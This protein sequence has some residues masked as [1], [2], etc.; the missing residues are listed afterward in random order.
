MGNYQHTSFGRMIGWISAESGNTDRRKLVRDANRVRRWVYSQ[1]D[2]IKLAV[3][4]EECVTASTFCLDCNCENSYVGISLPPEYIN[5]ASMWVNNSSIQMNSR[6][7]EYQDGMMRTCGTKLESNY[8]GVPAPTERD[9][10]PCG[11]C[12]FLGFQASDIADN[13]KLVY[14]Q[15]YDANGQEHT[16]SIKLKSGEYVQ[17][18]CEVKAIRQPS[19]ITLPDDLVGGVL[20]AQLDTF[21]ILSEYKP[22]EHKPA[23]RRMTLPVCDGQQVLVRGTR[24]HHDLYW[25][26]ETAETDNELAVIAVYRY[27][28]HSASQ[29]PT[30]GQQQLADY[31][32]QQAIKYLTGDQK[33]ETGASTVARF[34]H[35]HGIRRHNTLKTMG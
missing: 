5:A 6:W 30:D 23:Y 14:I 33:R 8:V 29:S 21:R 16:D 17:T 10:Y 19:G 4:V 31:H 25:N 27:L 11:A 34:T 22:W 28:K 1:Y 12:V 7:R 13:G 3:D 20:V 9:I 24:R 32:E 18:S 2:K 35:S 26:H 15:Y